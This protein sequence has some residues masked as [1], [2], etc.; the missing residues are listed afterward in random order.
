[1]DRITG[2]FSRPL[3]IQ[4]LL[5]TNDISP[6]V[7]SHLSKVYATLSLTVICA[8]LG[9]VAHLQFHIGGI[10]SAIATMGIMILLS[11]D[12]EGSIPKRLALVTAFGFFQGA[13]AGELVRYA[14][15][16]DPSILITAFL[17]TVVVFVSFSLSSMLSRRR[18]WLYLGGYLGSVLF[19]MFLLSL[20]NIFLRSQLAYDI[21]LYLGLLVFCG[22]IL[23]DTQ[24]IIEKASG[25]S[26]DFIWD[27]LE[28]FI[29]FVAVFIR[30][31]RILLEH[32]ERGKRKQNSNNR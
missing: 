9:V 17:A 19:Y 11:M 23:Y 1:M 16:V 5:K 18:S 4:A 7:Q 29:D 13:T 14:L 6:E 27:A 32:T 22:Y 28:L 30:V 25:G 31:L 10:L 24:L 26:T 21:N 2:A 15:H 3:D 12:R 8:I 20:A